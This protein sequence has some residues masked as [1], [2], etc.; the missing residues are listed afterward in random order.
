MDKPAYEAVVSGPVFFVHCYGCGKRV[1][2]G[3]NGAT[4]GAGR[5][6]VD[7]TDNEPKYKCITCARRE[8]SNFSEVQ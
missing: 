5:A 4:L 6:H 3:D 1:V 2:G 7:L 8:L